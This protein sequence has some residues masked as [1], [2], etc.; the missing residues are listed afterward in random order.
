MGV[1]YHIHV[2]FHTVT[3]VIAFDVNLMCT[4]CVSLNKSG[5]SELAKKKPE[6]IG[7][8]QS[9]KAAFLNKAD[10]LKELGIFG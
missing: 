3:P 2:G 7:L 10:C 6:I 1:C 8:E 4:D 5:C 9:I